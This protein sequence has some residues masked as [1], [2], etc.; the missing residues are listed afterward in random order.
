VLASCSGARLPE[1]TT[2]GVTA[3]LDRCDTDPTAFSVAESLGNYG[4]GICTVKNAYRITAMEGVT[5]SQ[6]AIVNCSVANAFR[7]WLNQTV[8]PAAQAEFGARVTSITVAASYA[9][10]ARNGQRGGKLSEHGF[11]NAIDVS[12]L[13][14]ADGHDVSV[15]RDYGRSGF[16]KQ[17]RQ[18]ACGLFSTVLGPGSDSHHRDH[19]HLDLANRRS[20]QTFCH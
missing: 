7:H 3:P 12:A 8:Q 17:V 10:R 18:R 6:P 20:G 15:E 5:F 13:Q 1:F 9:C 2:V 4:D 19:L 14:L 16:L 11:G